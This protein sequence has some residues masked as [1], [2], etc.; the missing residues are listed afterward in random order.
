M[1]RV[2]LGHRVV[3]E[4]GDSERAGFGIVRVMG[5][6]MDRAGPICARAGESQAA[7]E[8]GKNR[9]AESLAG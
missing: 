2:F 7:C 3:A 1:L 5:R 6:E 9:I 4:G 8:A